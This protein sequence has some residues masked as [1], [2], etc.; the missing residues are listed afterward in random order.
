MSTERIKEQISKIN[1]LDRNSAFI[2]FLSTDLVVTKAITADTASFADVSATALKAEKA[3]IADLAAESLTV[4]TVD[5]TT[6]DTSTLTADS[7]FMQYLSSELVVASE[8]NTNDLRA[9]LASIDTLT[10]GSA[11]V[12]YLQSL[13]SSTAI[14]TIDQEYVTSIV[15]NN[16][17]VADLAAGDIVLSNNMR[18]L[19]EN[20]ATQG[21]IMSGSEIQF[22]D[23]EGNV[24]ISIGYNNKIDEQ[25]TATVDYDHPSIIIKDS[26]GSIMLNSE[27]LTQGDIGLAPM[28]Q[29]NSISQ[30]KLAFDFIKTPEGQIVVQN[31][32]GSDS[33]WGQAITEFISSTSTAVDSMVVNTDIFYAIG[34]SS[35]IAP[36]QGWSTNSP[37]WESGKYIWQKTVTTYGDG[38][39]EE[40]NPVCI[41]A[42]SG[43][44]NL[45]VQI[46]SSNGNIFKNKDITTM[47]TCKV[48]Y[49]TADVTDQV[50]SFTW[51]K[52]DE[53]GDIDYEWNRVTSS[54]VVLL[55]NADVDNRASFT[56]TVE[57]DI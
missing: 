57:I 32:D 56:C 30:G 42:A 17:G 31:F 52:T 24:S 36:E 13:S 33:T 6:I 38:T 26:N 43:K 53:N 25:G 16:I 3:E 39:I 21:M 49:G 35:S 45:R 51:S 4:R 10:A 34:V 19:S 29:N 46:D 18:I 2:D 20:D 14:A 1:Y 50:T 44:S 9:K 27:G 15:A 11:F 12:N 7:A 37:Q 47:L 40:T 8:I 54:N 22:L 23:G 5:A 28:I 41:Q 55:T 48:Y